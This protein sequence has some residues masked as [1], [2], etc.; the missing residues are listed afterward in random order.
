MLDFLGEMLKTGVVDDGYPC[1]M[2]V[3]WCIW[4]AI[5]MV[6]GHFLLEW[7]P[8][9][10]VAAKDLFDRAEVAG[11]LADKEDPSLLVETSMPEALKCEGLVVDSFEFLIAGQ[12]CPFGEHLPHGVAGRS[13]L[14]D[15]RESSVASA[16]LG[17][18]YDTVFVRLMCGVSV[19]VVSRPAE[20]F[21]GYTGGT[22]GFSHS[23]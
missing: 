5:D 15:H 16:L 4:V 1:K 9:F 3:S 2:V 19:V 13:S 17:V 11:G 21:V 10:L 6:S 18:P 12:L 23:I 14:L 7:F 8:V 20:E 22:R